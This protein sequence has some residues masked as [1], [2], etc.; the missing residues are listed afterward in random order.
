MYGITRA[1]TEFRVGG[2]GTQGVV[3]SDNHVVDFTADLAP[4][5]VGYTRNI[6]Y[7]TDS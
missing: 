4:N 2:F 5:G 6:D 1:E 3:H 7:T